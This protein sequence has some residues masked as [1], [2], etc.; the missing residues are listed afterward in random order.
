M[1][2]VVERDRACFGPLPC[3]SAAAKMPLRQPMMKEPHGGEKH[4]AS[5]KKKPLQNSSNQQQKVEARDLQAQDVVKKS[6]GKRRGRGRGKGPAA[7][8]AERVMNAEAALAGGRAIVGPPVSS[9]G[10]GFCRRPGFGQIGTRCL[11]KANHFLA[12]LPD[13]DLNQYDVGCPSQLLK[14]DRNLILKS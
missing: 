10:I 4:L 6:V 13:K 8:G 9:K 1:L 3:S 7:A 2:A 14:A 12:Q 5:K 11:V